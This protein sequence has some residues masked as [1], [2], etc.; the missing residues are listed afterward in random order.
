[1]DALQV[2]RYPGEAP[3]WFAVL[4]SHALSACFTLFFHA[5]Q[6]PR[7][8]R[9]PFSSSSDR[10]EGS[11][12]RG[13][14]TH[15]GRSAGRGGRDGGPGR[16]PALRPQQPR[17]RAAERRRRA[18]WASAG[19]PP[20][21]LPS[22]AR[23]LRPLSPGAVCGRPEPRTREQSSAARVAGPA[24]GIHT[25]HSRPGVPGSATRSLRRKSARGSPGSST[26]HAPQPALAL[27]APEGRCPLSPRNSQ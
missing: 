10:G 23:P 14:G 1:M 16:S 18:G 17:L 19:A 4:L 2:N 25:A 5:S 12:R 11:A 8:V 24:P 22:S 27:P 3:G 15:Q 20:A 9:A 13:P 26:A 6:H 21:A 7:K